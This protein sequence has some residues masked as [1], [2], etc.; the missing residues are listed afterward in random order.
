LKLKATRSDGR[1]STGTSS[2]SSPSPTGKGRKGLKPGGGPLKDFFPPT[3]HLSFSLDTPFPL[4][5]TA[6]LNG[7]HPFSDSGFNYTYEERPS[8]ASGLNNILPRPGSLA[9]IRRGSDPSILLKMYN[10]LTK[11]ESAAFPFPIPQTTDDRRIPSPKQ[12]KIHQ[13]PVSI[14]LNNTAVDDLSIGRRRSSTQLD[15]YKLER[16]GDDSNFGSLGRSVFIRLLYLGCAA[17]A[18]RPVAPTTHSSQHHTQPHHSNP[19][20]PSAQ[21]VHNPNQ[22]N[23]LKLLPFPN[24]S[25]A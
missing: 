16:Q 22:Q 3:R 20:S 23:H 10:G 11:V 4:I 12:R 18:I 5:Q 21:Q 6:N 25:P 1:L 15:M 9:A 14:D 24:Q 19:P 2:S 8:S 7:D 17:D 13:T